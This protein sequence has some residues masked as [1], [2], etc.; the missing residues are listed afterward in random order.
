MLL[1]LIIRISSVAFAQNYT[2]ISYSNDKGLP[3]SQVQS[4]A[5]DA[6]GYLWAGTLG[7]LAKFN[8]KQFIPFQLESG[9]VN[10]RITKLHF[11]KA[12]LWV[13]HQG[14]ISRIKDGKVT[15][16]KLIGDDAL[17]NVTDI[18]RF[19]NQ[20]VF[21]VEGGGIYYI[22]NDQLKRYKLPNE[23]ANICRAL[24]VVNS[25][26]VIGTKDGIYTTNDLK[27]FKKNK[28]FGA[29]SVSDLLQKGKHIVI[30]TFN[31]GIFSSHLNLSSIQQIE[32]A[33][34]RYIY[35]GIMDVKQRLWICH[36]LGIEC[37]N[38]KGGN[39]QFSTA[40][41]LSINQINCVFQDKNGTL[42]LG[43]DGKGMLRFCGEEWSYYNSKNNKLISD[44]ILSGKQLDRNRYLF[45]SYGK[46]A[47]IM[48]LNGECQP[49][50]LK[51]SKVWG[52][53]TDRGVNYYATDEGLFIQ[54]TINENARLVTSSA[55]VFRTILKVNHTIYVGGDHELGKV[56]NNEFIAFPLSDL[57][58]NKL[59]IVQSILP[60][61]NKLVIASSKGLFQVD[62]SGANFEK[63]KGFNTAAFTLEIDAS[64][65]LWIGTENGLF[66]YNGISFSTFNIGKSSGGRFI[67]FLKNVN[68]RLFVGTNNGVY[69]IELG[70][71][72]S[73]VKQ[74]GLNSGLINLESNL[75]SCL[76]DQ[77][78][79]WFGTAE[80][81]AR[82]QLDAR[83]IDDSYAFNPS[84]IPISWS[85]NFQTQPHPRTLFSNSSGLNLS[86]AKNNLSFEFDATDLDDP[87]N[88]L[89][90]FWVEGLDQQW[91]LPTSNATLVLS[92]LSDGDYTIHVRCV[93]SLGNVSEEH[94]IPLTIRAPF[95]RTWW[96]ILLVLA[97]VVW[98][99]RYFVRTRLKREREANYRENLENKA[100]LLTLEQQ[101]LNASMNRH[102][103]FNSLN[104]IQY[105]INTQDKLSA[106][107]FLTNFAK[108][109]RKNLDSAAE[110]ENMVSLQQEIERLE[111]YLSLEAMRFKDRF[112]YEI[113]EGDVEVEQIEV[114]SM[115]LQP[116]VENSIIHGILP[117]ESQVGRIEVKMKQIGNQLEICIDDNGIGIEFSKTKKAAFA[118]DH[119][120][121]G[122]EIT[123]KRIELIRSMTK[124]DFDIIGPFQMENSDHSIKGTRVLIK[125]P[126]E[127]LDN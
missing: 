43:S 112:T 44:L 23:N 81:L 55:S 111:L 125:I 122:M 124:K 53:E 94:V 20:M 70:D 114:P 42:W 41:G 37:I 100:R 77:Q 52:I 60:Y 6:D 102:F 68:E 97:T 104:S 75:N 45:G 17:N 56:V 72:P 50:S 99:V 38:G 7:G 108:L 121:R 46:G 34:D 15:A 25:S 4:I 32:P 127:N 95:W 21:S 9:L 88:V 93:N 51:A 120:S 54:N 2:F 109:I 19:N 89:F 116:F 96:F 83:S 3:Q 39:K 86:Y 123:A 74:F 107:R 57:Q 59:G 31:D 101:S 119:R 40:N 18:A 10:N 84:I 113:D 48:D 110:N 28:A 87:D 29:I 26:L 24:L 115:L 92:N 33:N 64:D 8:G 49:V 35:Q 1:I 47:F 66:V 63:L 79:L 65:R 14:G 58:W 13:G 76:Y 71:A 103:I 105:F 69:V 91:R 36:D 118:G 126:L 106:N 117:D 90:Q 73:V 30:L 98:S 80:G 5:Q 27:I 11:D 82:Y 67:N 22:V 12:T 16:W 85:L 61:H 62:F 78:Y